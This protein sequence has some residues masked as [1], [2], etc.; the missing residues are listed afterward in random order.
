M[1]NEVHGTMHGVRTKATSSHQYGQ[2]CASFNNYL[3]W[4]AY[5]YGFYLTTM[6]DLELQNNTV[7]DSG[8]GVLPLIF[9]PASVTHEWVEKYISVND[10][11]FVGTT[12]D[13]DCN[14]E[15]PITHESS[16]SN[17]PRDGDTRNAGIVFPQFGSGG[18]PFPSFLFRSTSDK[19]FHIHKSNVCAFQ[20]LD[21]VNLGINS[22]TTMQSEVLCI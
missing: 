7:L 1:G 13:F 4:K 9:G 15:P 21:L 14:S 16:P 18:K 10:S 12:D 6:D 20:E 11:L 22:R 17:W 5:D 8:N 3:V 2:K 19:K